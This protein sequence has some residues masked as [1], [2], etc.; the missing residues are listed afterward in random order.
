MKH[1]VT[2]IAL[3]AGLLASSS[4]FAAERTV[5]FAVANMTCA[6]CPYIVEKSLT[7]VPGV[8][9]VA[10]SFKEMTAVVTFDDQKTTADALIA[11]ACRVRTDSVHGTGGCD[12][13]E[14]R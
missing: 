8:T 4:A 13:G 10:V 12:E 7:A 5:T 2:I 9:K 11:A 1:L 3:S 14:G 6:S